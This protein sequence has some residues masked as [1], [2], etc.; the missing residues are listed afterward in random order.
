MKKIFSLMWV[1]HSLTALAQ[2]DSVKFS[3]QNPMKEGVFL[4][5]K[6][7][8]R[9]TPI[10]KDSIYVIK[11]SESG[12]LGIK[13]KENEMF[14]YLL[15][16]I[17]MTAKVSSVYAYKEKQDGRIYI[18]YDKTF[19][20]LAT[21]GPILSFFMK[22]DY[23]PN[24]GATLYMASIYDGH[25]S[26]A[27]PKRLK[28]LIANDKELLKEYEDIGFKDRVNSVGTYIKKYDD[29]NSVYFLR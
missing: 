26:T 4:T 22:H 5:Y 11:K 17:K 10:S 24:I 2:E 3:L 25:F 29:R 19:Y 1:L 28:Q 20:Q 6:D 13:L 16:G 21:F 14:T 9:N 12:L 7:F 23:S 18:N 8:R 27:S 15:N